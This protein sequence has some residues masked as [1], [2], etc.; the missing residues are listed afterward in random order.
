MGLRN[1]IGMGGALMPVHL[2]SPLLQAQV[3]G[4]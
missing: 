2:H 4:V 1:I 3:G